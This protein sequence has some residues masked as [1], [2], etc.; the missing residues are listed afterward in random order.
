MDN[1]KGFVFVQITFQ[2][3]CQGWFILMLSIVE[4][5]ILTSKQHTISTTPQDQDHRN[6][7]DDAFKTNKL[8]TQHTS[9]HKSHKVKHSNIKENTIISEI[10]QKVF[11]GSEFWVLFTLIIDLGCYT[12]LVH[13]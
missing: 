10:I 12:N 1:S 4:E 9:Q 11:V 7:K 3:C 13:S 5:F 6:H 8:H 2:Y